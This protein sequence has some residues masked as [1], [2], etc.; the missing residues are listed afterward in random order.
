M[1][2]HS[3][4]DNVLSWI[5]VVFALVAAIILDENGTTNKWHAAIIWTVVTFYTVLIL[6]RR[7]WKS[8]RFWVLYAFF[9]VAHTFTMWVLFAMLLPRLLLGIL[10]VFPPAF[11]ESILIVGLIS[12]VETKIGSISFRRSSS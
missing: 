5:A 12:K 2:K 3:L 10:Y 11:V 1:N 9:V 6:G 4:S 7:K 8:W